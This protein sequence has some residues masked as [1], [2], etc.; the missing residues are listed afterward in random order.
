V[1]EGVGRRWAGWSKKTFNGVMVG[2]TAAVV[3]CLT[4]TLPILVAM[5]ANE[6]TDRTKAARKFDCILHDDNA[7]AP[8]S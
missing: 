5:S 4:I 3:A 8:V 2:V 7:Q 6:T 1:A